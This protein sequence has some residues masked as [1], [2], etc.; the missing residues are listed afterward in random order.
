[1]YC[2]SLWVRF[3]C[4]F[5]KPLVKQLMWLAQSGSKLI[6]YFCHIQ[7]SDHMLEKIYRFQV[8]CSNCSRAPTVITEV[9]YKS[10]VMHSLGA[11]GT[12]LSS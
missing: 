2:H 6:I 5:C 4:Q 10:K 3:M 11:H 9:K 12:S 1:M 7:V 8:E